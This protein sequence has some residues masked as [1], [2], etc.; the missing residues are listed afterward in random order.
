MDDS[1][2]VLSI[3]LTDILGESVFD[4]PPEVV[5]GMP[6]QNMNHGNSNQHGTYSG[7]SFF[8]VQPEYVIGMSSENTNSGNSNQQET[9]YGISR[10][11]LQP[12]CEINWRC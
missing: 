12:S 3:K 7:S 8:D 10:N 11:D 6:D 1:I 9:Y 5:L 2:T 4:E